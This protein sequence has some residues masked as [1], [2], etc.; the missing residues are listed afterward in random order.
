MNNK[1]VELYNEYR[2][3]RNDGLTHKEAL[4]EFRDLPQLTL[5]NL[6]KFIEETKIDGNTKE[7]SK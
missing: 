5:N 1:L 2:E 3:Y 4:S 6:I 7:E